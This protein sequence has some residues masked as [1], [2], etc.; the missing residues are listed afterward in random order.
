MQ[1]M[2]DEGFREAI[3]DTVVQIESGD[4][5]CHTPHPTF[6]DAKA[7]FSRRGRRKEQ[8]DDLQNPF[9]S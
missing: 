1:S 2:T 3:P 4:G 5:L 8:S 7:T 9:R 6:A